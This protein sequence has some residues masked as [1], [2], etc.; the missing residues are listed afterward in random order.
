MFNLKFNDMQRN[1]KVIRLIAQD[2]SVRVLFVV[3][4]VRGRSDRQ[5]FGLQKYQQ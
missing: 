1:I 4:A 2:H 3:Y 5:A